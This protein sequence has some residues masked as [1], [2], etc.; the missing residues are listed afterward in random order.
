MTT[1]AFPLDKNSFGWDSAQYVPDFEDPSITTDIEG[2]YMASR[3][4]H[5]RAPRGNWK[6]GWQMMNDVDFQTLMNFWITTKG[7]SNLFAWTDPYSG[8]VYASVRF[9]AKPTYKYVGK[10]AYRAWDVQV[11]LEQ[12]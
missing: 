4:R 10:G 3:P 7:R 11:Q 5:T 12:V 2:G 1:L 8:T 9:A 6:M